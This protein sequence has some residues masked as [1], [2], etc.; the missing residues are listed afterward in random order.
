MHNTGVKSTS[1]ENYPAYFE[2]LKYCMISKMEKNNY[3]E[4]SARLKWFLINAV[5]FFLRRALLRLWQIDE[6]W[7]WYQTK[8]NDK[9]QFREIPS[10]FK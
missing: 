7:T 1:F 4:P 8:G 5:N 3:S 9:N 10:Q 6:K 2:K